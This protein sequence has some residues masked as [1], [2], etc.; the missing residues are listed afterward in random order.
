[1]E[2]LHCI[3]HNLVVIVRLF[4]VVSNFF[5]QFF[6]KCFGFSLALDDL[7]DCIHRVALRLRNRC[8]VLL[9]CCDAWVVLVGILLAF[10][11]AATAASSLFMHWSC[12]AA[13]ILYLLAPSLVT[14]LGFSGSFRGFALLLCS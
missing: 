7:L 5:C 11:I 3:C 13:A 1:M 10:S 12:A 14:S 4:I 8:D 6:D 9:E 2:Q